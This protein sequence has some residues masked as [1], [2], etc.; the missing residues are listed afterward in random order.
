MPKKERLSPVSFLSPL[1]EILKEAPKAV[2]G[3]LE[4]LDESTKLKPYEKASLLARG[5]PVTKESIGPLL[6]TALQAGWMHLNSSESAG[7]SAFLLVASVTE[8]E[9]FQKTLKYINEGSINSTDVAVLA[10]HSA[11]EFLRNVANELDKVNSDDHRAD[12]LALVVIDA[13]KA[14][15]GVRK[16]HDTILGNVLPLATNE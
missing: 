15:V 3:F 13:L 5:L 4:Q 2:S 9:L 7:I 12:A 10:L 14:C 6:E 11:S 8:H 16:I 1:H